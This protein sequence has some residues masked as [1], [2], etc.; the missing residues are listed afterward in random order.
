[1]Q[2]AREDRSRTGFALIPIGMM[3]AAV[4]FFRGIVRPEAF[5][6]ALLAAAAL[7]LLAPRSLPRTLRTVGTVLLGLAAGFAACAVETARTDTTVFSG[8][9][10]VRIKGT[11]IVRERDERG[12]YRYLIDIVSTERPVLS[13]P[14]ERA[15]IVV[16]SRHDPLPIGSTYEGLVRLRPPAGPAY[17]GA[18]DFAFGAFFGGLGAY[19]FSLGA[20]APPG[21]IREPTFADR[22]AT[23]RL[24]MGDRIREVLPGA[25]GAVAA[26]LVTG[27]RAG[28]PEEINDDLRVTGLAHVLSIS[29]FHMALVA[30]FFMLATRLCLATIASLALR[31]PI[32]KLAAVVALA[33]T[34]FYF[35][36]AGDNAATERSFVMIAVMLGAILLDQPALTLRNVC[37]A[38]IVVVAFSPHVVMTAT[39]QMSFAATAAL[40][41]AYGAYARWRAARG[42]K[43]GGWLDPRAIGILV[44]GMALSSLIAGTATA[45]FAIHHFQRG[46][47]FSLIANVIATPIFSFWIM[48]LG[49]LAVLAMPFGLETW[50]LK[51]MGWGLDQ[52][53]SLAAW[54]ADAFPDYPTGQMSGTSV[55]CFSAAILILSFSASAFRWFALAPAI[56][57]LLVLRP[58]P[59]PELLIFESGREVA[60]IDAA[61]TLRSLRPRPPGFV[62][63][64]WQRAYPADP[65]TAARDANGASASTKVALQAAAVDPDAMSDSFR[66][67]SNVCYARTHSGIQIGWSDDY[68][69]LDKL[70]RT[71]DVAIMARAVRTRTC[72][73]G[74]P[75]VTLRTLRQTGSLTLSRAADGAI[76]LNGSIPAEPQ[77]WNRH[78]LAAWPEYWRREDQK[79][80]TTSPNEAS[81]GTLSGSA[82][83]ARPASPEP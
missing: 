60:A 82:G 57:G 59:P 9:A 13:R 7:L 79:A 43:K 12:R 11:V 64:Q 49:M 5:V 3:I 83:S 17:P 34:G 14:P 20:P 39:F 19:G 77:E 27:E 68:E 23:L 21:P 28:I 38:A 29:G 52:V 72:S 37:L 55:L 75:L 70:C 36:L 45:P 53:F 24:A 32:K 2:L 41:G 67:E 8:E 6:T 16:S 80:E 74:T 47:P 76:V 73:N 81:P 51:G 62:W 66:C 44:F 35:L 33:G 46:A 54:L 15:R 25:T 22:I 65:A 42:T 78:R 69:T 26:A 61:G 63:D 71:S 50:P 18:Y 31:W 40:V 30:G 1:M 56:A 58:G 4:C 48:P 10:T